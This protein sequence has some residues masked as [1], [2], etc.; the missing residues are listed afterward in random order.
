MTFAFTTYE[1]VQIE[2]WLADNASNS[3]TENQEG[4]H[5]FV[6][7]VMDGKVRY[8]ISGKL[9]AEHSGNYYPDAP[10][11]MN[12][13]L[14]FINGGLTTSSET[15]SYQEDIDWIYH[16]AGVVLTPEQVNKNVRALRESGTRFID[17][18][19]AASPALTSPCDL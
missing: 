18:V 3:V 10:M 1:T 5:T 14:W 2:P 4:W 12:F 17:T 13:N 6:V 9:V 15:R 16:E 11:S 7:Q 19:P 8:F